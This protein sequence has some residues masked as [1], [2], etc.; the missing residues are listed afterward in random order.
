MPALRLG[1]IGL[2]LPAIVGQELRK[3]KTTFTTIDVHAEM[4]GRS[5]KADA[6]SEA[7][8]QFLTCRE[9][10]KAKAGWYVGASPNI[11]LE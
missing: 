1:V 2:V 10:V 8:R 4:C 3:D 9:E 6:N 7:M 11:H 5:R